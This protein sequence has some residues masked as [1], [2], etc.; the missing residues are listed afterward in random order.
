LD[1]RLAGGGWCVLHAGHRVLPPRFDPV[2]AC[3]LA[4]VLHRRQCLPLRGGDGAGDVA[5]LTLPAPFTL[6]LPPASE[7]G[8][9]LPGSPTHAERPPSTRTAAS[10]WLGGRPCPSVAHR[11]R[12]R[13]AGPAGAGA[14]LGL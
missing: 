5:G 9:A 13:R 1:L 3:H 12:G 8:A 11:G 4:S 7:G 14:A 6:V 10:P 2:F